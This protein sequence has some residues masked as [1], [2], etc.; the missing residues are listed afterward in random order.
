VASKI[1]LQFFVLAARVFI[2]FVLKKK[3]GHQDMTSGPKICK[4]LLGGVIFRNNAKDNNCSFNNALKS[5]D[6]E[7]THR[8]MS[9][10]FVN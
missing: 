5:I 6:L 10:R 7:L 9:R 3:G 8:L 1:K 2:I 4:V